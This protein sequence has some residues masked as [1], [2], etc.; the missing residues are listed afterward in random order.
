MV[1]IKQDT[2]Y[3]NWKILRIIVCIIHTTQKQKL[4][5]IKMKNIFNIKIKNNTINDCP[6][7]KYYITY[8]INN[9]VNKFN[10]QLLSDFKFRLSKII[11]FN[12]FI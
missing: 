1:H 7:L 5:H 12:H 3:I 4:L 2:L 9:K 10:R 11:Y 6:L 8:A